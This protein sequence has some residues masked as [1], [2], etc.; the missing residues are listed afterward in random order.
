[1]ATAWIRWSQDTGTSSTT[2]SCWE[3]W[4]TDNTTSTASAVTIT[5]DQAF[6]IWSAET[7]NGTS[8]STSGTADYTW[9]AWSEE[10]S[11]S[12]ERVEIEV[13]PEES[14][15]YKKKYRSER[16]KRKIAEARAKALL[17]I[18]IGKKDLEVYKE[19]GRLLVKGRKYDYLLDENGGV[20]QVAKNKIVDLCVHLR[21]NHNLPKTDR[22]IGLKM[23][24]EADEPHFLRTA[25]VIRTNRREELPR[26]AGM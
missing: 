4:S 12:V 9:R 18:L 21:N 26:A 25:N 13:T 19:T 16:R 23:A 24:I 2:D 15:A 17:C 14:K 20:K 10:T 22:V 11:T 8:V 3:S 5:E 7:D 1:M 6:Q